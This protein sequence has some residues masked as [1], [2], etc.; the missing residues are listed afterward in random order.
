MAEAK[1]VDAWNEVPSGSGA[2]RNLKL[3]LDEDNLKLWPLKR[4]QSFA[5]LSN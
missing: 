1:Y 5:R 3:T 2:C 4:L